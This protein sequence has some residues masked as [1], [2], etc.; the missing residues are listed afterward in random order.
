MKRVILTA[1]CGAVLW[2]GCSFSSAGQLSGSKQNRL[3]TPVVETSDQTFKR[4]VLLSKETVLV[5]F[6]ASWCGP[7][8]RMAPIVDEIADQFKGKVKVFKVD[9]DKSPLVAETLGIQSIPTLAVFKNGAVIN[10]SVGLISKSDLADMLN[11]SSQLS[12][13]VG[14]AKKS[15]Y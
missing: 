10:Q 8:R 6:Y 4:D 14:R 3:S 11:Q 5:D 13:F 15:I 7:C 2:S 9:I 1:A 12:S